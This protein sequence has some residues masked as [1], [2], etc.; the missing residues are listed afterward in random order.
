MNYKLLEL[1]LRTVDS[2]P[3][4][5]GIDLEFCKTVAA[6]ADAFGYDSSYYNDSALIGR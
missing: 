4:F 6:S 1:L 2:I 5:S 3:S